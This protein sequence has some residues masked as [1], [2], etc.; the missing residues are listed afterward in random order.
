MDKNELLSLTRE[1]L[2]A[3]HNRLPVSFTHGDGVWLWDQDGKRYLDALAGIAVDTLGHGNPRLVNAIATQAQRLIHVSNNYLIPQ[4]A[5]LGGLLAKLSGLDRAFF[6]NS[7]TEANE[8][9]IKVARLYGHQRGV[10]NPKIVVLDK[11][12]HGRTLG[13]L[14][15]TASEKIREGFGPLLDGLIRLPSQRKAIEQACPDKH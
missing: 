8:C 11:A 15:A 7:G 9:A 1:H 6:V 2:A 13:S 5:E 10:R 14:S 12:F 4:Q 3:T